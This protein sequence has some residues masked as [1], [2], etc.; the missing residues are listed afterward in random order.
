MEAN[1]ALLKNGVDILAHPF[2]YFLRNRLNPPTDLYKPLAQ[3][4]AA[5]GTAVELNYHTNENDPL[6]F[7]IC[8]EYGVPIALGSD[9]HHLAEV[10]AFGR[11][12]SLL[13]EIC[14][15]EQLHRIL[16]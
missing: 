3:L 12:L 10:G 4:L 6:F 11:H 9:A 15:D 16:F 2:R 5:S 8:L 14:P 7:E 13:K 1:E